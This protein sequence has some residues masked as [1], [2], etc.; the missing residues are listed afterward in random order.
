MVNKEI[1]DK[2]LN[3]NLFNGLDY[4]KEI[5]YDDKIKQWI[6]TY[7]CESI[8]K[9]LEDKWLKFCKDNNLFR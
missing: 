2:I 5:I 6:V 9:G 4:E 8:T 7:E 1:L 3:Y